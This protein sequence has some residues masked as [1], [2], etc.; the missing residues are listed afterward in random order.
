ML[1]RSILCPRM[2]SNFLAIMVFGSG[3][4]PYVPSEL[5]SAALK[6]GIVVVVVVVVVWVGLPPAQHQRP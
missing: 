1:T 2:I 3:A 5:A 6:S 4:M